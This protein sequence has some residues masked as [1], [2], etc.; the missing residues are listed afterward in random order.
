MGYDRFPEGLIDEKTALL[1]DLQARGGRLVFTHDPKVAMGR[2]TR[3]A[4]NRFGLADNQNEVVQ[5]AE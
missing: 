2:L 3:D 4:K 1:E 5:L